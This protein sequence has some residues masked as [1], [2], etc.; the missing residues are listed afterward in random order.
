MWVGGADGGAYVRCKV[1]VARDVDH[2]EIWNDS[3]GYL[4]EVGDYQVRGQARAATA[5]ELDEIMFPD[6]AG[7]IYLANHIVLDRL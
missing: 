4:S 1:Y 5:Q 2:C 3:T 6:F 7:H